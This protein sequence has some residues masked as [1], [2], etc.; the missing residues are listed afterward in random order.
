MR[1]GE[2]LGLEPKRPEERKPR[3]REGNMTNTY[4]A[5]AVRLKD[6]SLIPAVCGFAGPLLLKTKTEAKNEVCSRKYCELEPGT[7]V[8]VT[9]IVREVAR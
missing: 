2:P 9:F 5:W 8:R 1:V 4:A 6:G 3:G 7:P